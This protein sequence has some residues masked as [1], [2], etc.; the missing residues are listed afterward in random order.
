YRKAILFGQVDL[1]ST[2]EKF[3]QELEENGVNEIIAEMQNQFDAFL[4]ANAE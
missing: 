3:N 2:L 1:D 4:A